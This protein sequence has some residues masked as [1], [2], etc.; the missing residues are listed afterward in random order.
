MRHSIHLSLLLLVLLPLAAAGQQ[1]PT[2]ADETLNRVLKHLESGELDPAITELE[3]ALAQGEKDSR[4]SQTLGALYL[5][6]DRPADAVTILTPLADSPE[7]EPAV[8][9]NAGRAAAGVGDLD[10]AKGYLERSLAM[11]PVSPAARELGFVR[12]RQGNLMDAFLLLR[13][14]SR[15]HPEDTGALLAATSCAV[16]LGR[17]SDAE[18]VLM[19]LPLDLPAANILRGRVGLLNEDGWGALAV[20]QPLSES[21]PDGLEPQVLSVLAES[22]LL[23]GQPESALQALEGKAGTDPDLVRLQARAQA[24]MGQQD[25]AIQTLQPVAESLQS[26]IGPDSPDSD[27]ILA[28][29]VTADYGQ[30]LSQAGR[31]SD[32]LPP[33]E[34]ATAVDPSNPEAWEWLSAALAAEGRDEESRTAL[35]VSQ[36]LRGTDPEGAALSLG[37][38]AND[39]TGARLRWAMHLSSGGNREAALRTVRQE[40]ILAPGDPRP[41]LFEARLLSEMGRL[42]EALDVA[43]SAVQLAPDIADSYYMRGVVRLDIGLSGPA[44]EDL[45]KTITMAPQHTAAMNDLAV[46]LMAK[47]ENEEAKLLLEQVLMLQP[48]DPLAAKNLAALSEPATD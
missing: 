2:A 25:A 23:V 20:I 33:L 41:M 45:R 27:R 18:D 44:E 16:A 26:S 28:A 39:P 43:E 32:A 35:Q 21:P 24:A 1:E 30:M 17:A 31:S 9:Y 37:T 14:W 11:T 22:Y 19:T 47:D 4:V 15:L 48:D 42:Q 6:A 13:P 5:E 40:A 46:L 3:E 36:I 38:L 34:Y 10:K 7:A 8:L 12:L 29:E